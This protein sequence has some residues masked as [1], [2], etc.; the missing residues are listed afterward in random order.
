MKG[1]IF[2]N[3]K[4]FF[5][6]CNNDAV[7]QVKSTGTPV[8]G[9]IK[10]VINP[11]GLPPMPALVRHP[12]LSGMPRLTIAPQLTGGVSQKI[13]LVRN[14]DGKG[15]H[16]QTPPPPPLMRAA[17][18]PRTAV[19]NPNGSI[20]AGQSLLIRPK[21]PSTPQTNVPIFVH[22]IQP[23]STNMMASMSPNQPA[24]GEL[25]NLPVNVVNHIKGQQAVTLSTPNGRFSLP[26]NCFKQGNKTYKILLPMNTFPQSI[27][28]KPKETH[29][30]TVVP[31]IPQNMMTNKRNKRVAPREQHIDLTEDD[32]DVCFLDK[33]NVGT[34]CLV[35]IFQ[36]L[37][38]GDKMR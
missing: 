22:N 12:H 25:L 15:V 28:Q 26:P 38:L 14:P 19:I 7:S 18:A 33:L 11:S 35:Q 8:I 24:S 29:Q 23:I 37:S 6:T 36:Y 9:S 5:Q 21:L 16:I 4:V 10:T 13:R 30:A 20:G 34:D 3:I 1:P 17:P 27:M 31:R 2:R 32:D